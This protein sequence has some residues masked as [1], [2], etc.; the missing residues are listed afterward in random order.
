MT[1]A[2]MRDKANQ[3]GHAHAQQLDTE[4]QRHGEEVAA[5]RMAASEARWVQS[6]KSV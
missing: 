4:A 1:V 6:V 5:L 3:L 2:L